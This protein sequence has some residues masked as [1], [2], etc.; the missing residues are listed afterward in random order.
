LSD[1]AG[2]LDFEYVADCGRDSSQL[3]SLVNSTGDASVTNFFAETGIALATELVATGETG[4]AIVGI[5]AAGRGATSNVDNG[6]FAFGST[7]F[8]ISNTLL[9]WMHF[10]FRRS[11]PGLP[12]NNCLQW[13]H[14]NANVL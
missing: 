13:G 4:F 11:I 3:D 2:L 10:P 1:E 12:S 5:G 7:N 8:S 9:Q 6:G 14:W